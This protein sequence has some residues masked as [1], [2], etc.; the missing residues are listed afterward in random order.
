MTAERSAA[1][2]RQTKETDVSV[3]LNLDGAG[4]AEVATGIPFLD[5][6]L[7]ALAVHARLDLE[8]RARG[9]LEVDAHHTV[10]DV[11]LVLGESLAEALGDRSGIARFGDAIVPL[12]DSRATVAVDCGGRGYAIIDVPLRGVA[13]G[14]LPATL[15]PHFLETLALRSG[16]TLHVVASG[17]DDHHVAE[18]TFKALARALRQAC[19]VDPAL[20]GQSASTK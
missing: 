11:A 16:M 10:E 13:I 9:D 2:Q 1:R 17:R 19:A 8:V 5:H 6:L 20:R 15:V 7:R 4:V 18:A 3:R 14:S 12:D